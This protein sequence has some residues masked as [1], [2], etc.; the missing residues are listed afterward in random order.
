MIKPFSQFRA[1]HSGVSRY[2]R[3]GLQLCLA[4][5]VGLGSAAAGAAPTACDPATLAAK[6]QR[7][8]QKAQ[9][10]D[11]AAHNEAANAHPS[12]KKIIY[13]KRQSR[14][15]QK[16]ADIHRAELGRCEANRPWHCKATCNVEPTDKGGHCPERVS[17]NG[18]GKT[19]PAACKAAQKDAN[20]NVPKGCYKRHCDCDCS[21]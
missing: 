6:M 1:S 3:T 19:R 5:M 9:D 21:R 7:E 15:H 10:Y 12:Q 8:E 11:T 13:Y 17:G 4:V 14:N 2:A 16:M 20:N 18:N